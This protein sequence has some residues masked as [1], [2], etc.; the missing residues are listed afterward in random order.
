MGLQGDFT[1]WFNLIFVCFACDMGSL[2]GDDGFRRLRFFDRW[3]TPLVPK[4]RNRLPSKADFISKLSEK[5]AETADQMQT[6]QTMYT[7]GSK[8]RQFSL[9]S[10]AD[11]VSHDIYGLSGSH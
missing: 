11:F 8:F 5:M 9:V 6:K 7:Q 4:E 1:L 3:H 2:F 10:N